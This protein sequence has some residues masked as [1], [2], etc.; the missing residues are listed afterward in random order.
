MYFRAL[1]KRHRRSA[2]LGRR[3]QFEWLES[4]EM[5]SATLPKVTKVEVASTAWTSS[6]LAKVATPNTVS[7]GY[8]IPLGS[9]AQSETLAWD[10]IDQITITFNKDVNVDAADLSLSGVNTTNYQ[11]SGFRYDPIQHTATWTLAAA[12]NKDRVRIDLDASGTNPVRDLDG[13]VLDGEWTNNS[14]V[15]S[16]NGTAG[17]DFEFAFNVLP[18]DV[19]NTGNITSYDYVYIRQLEGK[20]ASDSGYIAKRDIDGNGV[21]NATDWQKALDRMSQALPGGVAAGT[22]NDAPTAG[23]FSHLKI[24]DYVND[25]AISLLGGFGDLESG[26]SGL[27]YSL[28]S[29]SNSELFD[30]AAIDG[31]TKSL[32]LNA[33]ESASGRSSIVIRATDASGLTVDATIT[34]DVNYE[35][36]PPQIVDFSISKS[37]FNMYVVSGQVID[38]SDVSSYIV[39]FSNMFSIRSAVDENGYF[40]FA[41][42]LPPGGVGTEYAVVQD[43]QGL[44]SLIYHHEINLT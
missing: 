14:S 13:N 18:T 26:S 29:V 39:T 4:K 30:T 12:I 25:I 20:T 15:T 33:A 9:S 32:V 5:L 31:A 8:A 24:D 7:H 3:L 28:L 23:V 6:F 36:Q 2:N 35:N 34:V 16:G 41:V 40:E 11:F 10:N 44:S 42:E 21:I 27:T 19:N 43:T 17:G 38:D 22:Y 1:T 37:G